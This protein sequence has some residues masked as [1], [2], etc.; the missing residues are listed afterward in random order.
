MHKPPVITNF[1]MLIIIFN[2]C[3]GFQDESRYDRTVGYQSIGVLFLHFGVQC[4]FVL[5]I[6][7]FG[8]LLMPLMSINVFCFVIFAHT[9]HTVELTLITRLID[10]VCTAHRS[11]SCNCKTV[12]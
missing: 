1:L 2:R 9:H 11:V 6:F 5:C 4:H 10:C 12:E 7:V 3:A 8:H